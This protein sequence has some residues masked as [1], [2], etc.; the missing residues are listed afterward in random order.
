VVSSPLYR[1]QISSTILA[2]EPNTKHCINPL[3]T[4]TDNRPGEIYFSPCI[5]WD[6][7]K[8]FL[9]TEKV[10]Y[11]LLASLENFIVVCKNTDQ[12]TDGGIVYRY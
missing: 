10:H 2:Q 9:M 11:E 7:N 1:K 6:M 3:I 12:K 5:F 8:H 4:S